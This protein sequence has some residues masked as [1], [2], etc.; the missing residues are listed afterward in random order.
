[1][2]AGIGMFAFALW[3]RTGRA[4]YLIRDRLGEKSLYHRWQNGVFLFGSEIKALAAHPAF[5]GD[6][7]GPKPRCAS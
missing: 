4:L 2:Q 1:M 6:R 3:D 7:E 5:G